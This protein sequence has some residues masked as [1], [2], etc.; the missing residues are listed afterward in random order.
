MRLSVFS[1]CS[2]SHVNA[3]MHETILKMCFVFKINV[4]QLVALNSWYY[5][6]N[7]WHRQSMD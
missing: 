6:E 4:F 3:K 7:I 1:K 5:G 2:Q